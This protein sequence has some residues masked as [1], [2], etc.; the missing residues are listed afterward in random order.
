MYCAVGDPNPPGAIN[1][2]NNDNNDNVVTLF[3]A[4]RPPACL[5]SISP[6]KTFPEIRPGG[7][8][9]GSSLV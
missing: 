7:A 4:P 5:S 2:G 8:G 9:W 6:E 1:Q 3:A